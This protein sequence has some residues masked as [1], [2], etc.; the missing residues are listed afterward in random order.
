MLFVSKT[1][2]FQSLNNELQVVFIFFF[3]N[4]KVSEL[5][6][7]NIVLL[8]S[9]AKDGNS[10]NFVNPFLIVNDLIEEMNHVQL[11]KPRELFNINRE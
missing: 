8:P 3:L 4:N 5:K 10:K 6:I 1:K 2:Q 9:F 7:R 11:L